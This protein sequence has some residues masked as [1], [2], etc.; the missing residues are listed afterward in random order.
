MEYVIIGNSAAGI[1]AV[2][3]IRE[4]DQKGS[5]TLI[6]SEPYLAYSRPAICEYL[7]GLIDYRKILYRPRNFYQ[8]QAVHVLLAKKVIS[9]DVKKERVILADG[10][11]ISYKRLL[12][13]T[14]ATPFIPPIEGKDRASVFVFRTLDDAKLLKKALPS[15]KQALIYGGGL[16]ALKVADTLGKLNIPTTIV[17]RSRLMRA[18]LDEEAS[19]IVQK[20]LSAQGIRV[21]TGQKIR[22]ICGPQDRVSYVRLENGDKIDCQLVI[23]A[24]GVS[25]NID[26]VSETPIKI[27]RGIIVDNRM[28]TNVKGILA[29]GDVCEAPNFLTKERSIVPIWPN[30]Y[31]QGRIAGLNMAGSKTEFKGSLAMNS[32]DVLGLPIITLGISNPLEPDYQV[33]KRAKNSSYR[34]IVFRNNKIVG[35][36]LINSIEGAGIITSLIKDCVDA[37]GFK[38]Q[39]LREDFGLIHLPKPLRKME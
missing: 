27:N 37:S 5:I 19:K 2:E 28:Q 30:A 12:I 35:A 17:V 34:K 22:E 20:H 3:A 8:R 24:V 18:A 15:T 26:L 16:I 39:L 9:I 21:I 29:A 4:K 7:A 31:A 11:R 1:G 6:S 33:L 36:I 10:D 13:S 14:G 23:L 38:R 32:L 25:P